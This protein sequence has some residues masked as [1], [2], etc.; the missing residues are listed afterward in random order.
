[1]LAQEPIDQVR[2]HDSTINRDSNIRGPAPL[3][4]RSEA[5]AACSRGFK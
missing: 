2:Q 1:L 4:K 3:L 5:N